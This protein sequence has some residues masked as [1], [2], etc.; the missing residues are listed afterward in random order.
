[1]K[2]IIGIFLVIAILLIVSDLLQGV[3]LTILYNPVGSENI[4]EPTWIVKYSLTAAIITIM[5]VPVIKFYSR[6]TK[7]DVP[8]N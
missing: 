5:I 2:K 6:I 1:M 3:I 4:Y 7:K 8:L